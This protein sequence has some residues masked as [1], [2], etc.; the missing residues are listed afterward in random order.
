MPRSERAGRISTPVASAA[1]DSTLWPP[2]TLGFH[3]SIPLFA[4]LDGFHGLVDGSCRAFRG[5]LRFVG[6]GAESFV[7]V[8]WGLQHVSEHGPQLRRVPRR[9]MVLFLLY[10]VPDFCVLIRRQ[11]KTAK[12]A[13]GGSVGHGTAP[14]FV[15]FPV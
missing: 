5:S 15:L 3:R 10:V 12:G 8:A 11:G 13:L 2:H 9:A 14:G 7:V 4:G 6:S 1:W